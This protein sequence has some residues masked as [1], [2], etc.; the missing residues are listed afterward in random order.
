MRL[1][2]ALVAAPL[3]LALV[4]TGAAFLV[5]GMS[6]PTREGV[7]TVTADASV[8][9][10][11]LCYGFTFTFGLAGII[12]LWFLDQSGALVWAIAGALMGALGGIVFGTFFM[13]GVERA[14]LMSFGL[15]GWALFILIRWVAGIR[16]GAGD[17]GD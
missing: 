15:G 2:V 5:A 7:M 6:E 9:M 17:A 16:A 12:G 4:L 11:T 13:D 10:L 8:A 1:A 3:I 14:L